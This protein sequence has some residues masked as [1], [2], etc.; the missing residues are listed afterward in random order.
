MDRLDELAVFAAI[1]D[2]GSLAAAGRRLRRSPPA[3]TRA[4]AALEERT[5]A[6]LLERT[7]RNLAPTEAGLRLGEQA[8]RV[9]ADYRDAMRGADAEQKLRG[10]LRVT[11]PVIFG[12]KHVTPLVSAFLAAFPA[13]QVELVLSDGNLDLIEEGLDIAVRIG[14]LADSGM[15]VRR[16]GQVR[17]VTVASPGYLAG[18]G[19]PERPADL[20]KHDIIFTSR[21][22]D[23]VA[24]RF[25]TGG[26]GPVVRLS[27]R[28]MV[29]EGEA[30]LFA[31][32]EGHG[33]TRALSYQVAED[34]A[35]G[36]L[37]RLLAR[38][39]PPPLPVQL[40][41]PSARNLPLRVRAF[42]DHAA[43]RLGALE[44]IGGP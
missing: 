43:Q 10:L 32:R 11:A 39:E 27:P 38:F 16:V 41:V 40:V 20:A 26:R 8:R 14:K 2:T 34:F 19:V 7:T 23:P 44:V 3:V 21:R 17:R 25:G 29:N 6:R 13:M 42:L 36:A 33:I 35:A 1:L 15:V 31:A 37:V 22:P 24:W 30:A 18:K 4:L 5:G 9:L 28:L 12:R